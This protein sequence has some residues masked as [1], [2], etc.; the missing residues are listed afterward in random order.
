MPRGPVRLVSYE[1]GRRKSG[2][3][4]AATTSRSDVLWR[5]TGRPLHEGRE[6][7]GVRVGPGSNATPQAN[8]IA[9]VEELGPDPEMRV[10]RSLR[11]AAGEDN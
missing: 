5:L 7:P 2:R 1:S 11:P 9:P 10:L 8:P 4:I 6:Q 3:G